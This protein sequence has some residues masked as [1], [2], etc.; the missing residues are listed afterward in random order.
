MNSEILKGCYEGENR[1]SCSTIPM[2]PH[3]DLQSEVA[4]GISLETMIHDL[5]S[6]KYSSE[7]ADK[8]FNRTKEQWHPFGDTASFYGFIKIVSD[9]C[10][11]DS[12][13][14]SLIDTIEPC[15]IRFVVEKCNNQT[16]N[17][18]KAV[19]D[20]ACGQ[21]GFCYSCSVNNSRT[22]SINNLAL[23]FDQ[24][25]V[26]AE[27]KKLG[28]L[29]VYKHEMTFPESFRSIWNPEIEK[30]WRLKAEDCLISF[31][32]KRFSE[33]G[34]RIP[35]K[36]FMIFCKV[37]RTSSDYPDQMHP[38][39]NFLIPNL[40]WIPRHK[41]R[42]TGIV[43]PAR[44]H[45]YDIFMKD[46]T[47]EMD[48]FFRE[49][50]GDGFHHSHMKLFHYDVNGEFGK[51]GLQHSSN[52]I[53]RPL[54]HDVLKFFQFRSENDSDIAVMAQWYAEYRNI[55]KGV[56]SWSWRNR[57]ESYFWA[58]K[59]IREFFKKSDMSCP[60]CRSGKF[61]KTAVTVSRS[62]LCSDKMAMFSV[63]VSLTYLSHLSHADFLKT[64][65]HWLSDGRKQFRNG[66]IPDLIVD[67]D[68]RRYQNRWIDDK[69]QQDAV[70]VWQDA[71]NKLQDKLKLAR[72]R[73]IYVVNDGKFY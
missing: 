70:F 37:H 73:P 47:V 18:K 19:A 34:I 63:L 40:F 66:E 51:S 55:W 57:K 61:E 72:K 68:A 30:T 32:Q 54:I 14:D 41:D 6:E 5:V 23:M 48:A 64:Y 20:C 35:K 60:V 52:Y 59:T 9:G 46:C 69:K 26:I 8:V 1:S 21:I 62:S 10:H 24:M 49:R 22:Q 58:M 38:H 36:S 53:M 29:Q 42:K 17:M 28:S 31:M 44:F 13:K 33:K 50:L 39:F 3:H 11:A 15:H 12:S 7:N 25:N 71:E 27:S 56:K 67:F 43:S 4:D 45:A 16:C 2:Q 65:S